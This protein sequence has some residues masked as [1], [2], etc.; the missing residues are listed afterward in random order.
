VAR[1]YNH[2]CILDAHGHG[3]IIEP[4]Q[5]I[6]VGAVV[7]NRVQLFEVARIFLGNDIRSQGLRARP[8][9]PCH[10]PAVDDDPRVDVWGR[11]SR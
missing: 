2:T 4:D 9:R 6:H 5:R 11:P 8:G 1:G 10:D 3:V 7:L